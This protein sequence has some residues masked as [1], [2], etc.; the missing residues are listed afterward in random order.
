MGS[1]AQAAIVDPSVIDIPNHLDATDVVIVDELVPQSS[2]GHGVLEL[3]MATKQT[4][5]SP[6][7]AQLHVVIVVDGAGSRV[8]GCNRRRASAKAPPDVV[9]VR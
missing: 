3:E 5:G 7:R 2:L 8:P 1:P 6:R 4:W 9:A